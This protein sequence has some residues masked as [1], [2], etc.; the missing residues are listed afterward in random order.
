MS[1][2]TT[3][4]SSMAVDGIAR[5]ILLGL[6]WGAVFHSSTDSL[7]MFDATTAPPPLPPTK[8]FSEKIIRVSRSMAYSSGGFALFLGTFSGVSCSCEMLRGKKDSLNAF[9]GG[10]SA[11]TVLSLKSK[12]PQI[13]IK[14]AIG[15]GIL[16]GIISQIQ[17]GNIFGGS[18]NF[19]K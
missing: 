17:G 11:G 1:E 14:S 6:A 3:P 4:C 9:I 7:M 13:I 5:G 12:A 2:P 15:T 10:A 18:S 19:D 16:T 8:S